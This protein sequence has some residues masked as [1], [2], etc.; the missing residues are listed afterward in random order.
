LA[1]T[2]C[3]GIVQ[4]Y[5]VVAPGVRRLHRGQHHLAQDGWAGVR[6]EDSPALLSGDGPA[7]TEEWTAEASIINPGLFNC[8]RATSPLDNRLGSSSFIFE[9]LSDVISNPRCIGAERRL[10]G[11]LKKRNS[12]TLEEN[13]SNVFNRL[14]GHWQLILIYKRAAHSLLVSCGLRKAY[15]N[16]LCL[17][18]VAFPLL[19]CPPSL[20]KNQPSAQLSSK[21][22]DAYQCDESV[23]VVD[24]G[25]P[26]FLRLAL[27]WMHAL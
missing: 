2:E 12:C 15:V 5:G 9:H 25:N 16:W 4:S 22:L 8:Y 7:K 6:A 1:G 10:W 27:S 11:H 14:S 13:C 18:Y 24:S 21:G 3:Q 17:A 20:D 19:R 26:P 23:T